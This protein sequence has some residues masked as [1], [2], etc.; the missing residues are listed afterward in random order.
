MNRS[1][2]DVAGQG[3][4]TTD[5]ALVPKQQNIIDTTVV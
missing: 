3:L 1:G 5:R 2:G 4:S